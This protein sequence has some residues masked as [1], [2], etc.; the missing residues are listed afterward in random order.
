M[1]DW[2]RPFTAFHVR[3]EKMLPN[4]SSASMH[5]KQ[6]ADKTKYNIF[7]VASAKAAELFV[8]IPNFC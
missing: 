5:I 7:I 6:L 1:Y 8:F 2:R 3:F 4:L